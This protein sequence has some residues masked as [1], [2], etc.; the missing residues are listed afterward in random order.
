[1]KTYIALVRGINVG[2]H[3]KFPK[4]AQL[5]FLIDLKL[6]NPQVYIHTGNWVFS[7]ESSEVDINTLVSEKIKATYNWELPIIIL[8][9]SAFKIIISNCPFSEEK[10]LESYFT[11][12][13]EAPSATDISLFNKISYPEEEFYIGKRCVYFYSTKSAARVKINNNFI[14]R[15][16]NVSATSRNY[17]TMVALLKMTN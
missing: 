11:L 5:R 12:L 8:D 13:S 3:K 4:A 15:K 14:E 6:K 9:A 16:L 2:G 7:S 1:M 17:K 10:K